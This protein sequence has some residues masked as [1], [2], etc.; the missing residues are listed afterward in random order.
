MQL[1]C[2][3]A[4]FGAREILTST[5]ISASTG[6]RANVSTST[7]TFTNTSARTSR[8][9]GSNTGTGIRTST[10]TQ[11]IGTGSYCCFRYCILLVVGCFGGCSSIASSQPFGAGK[12]LMTFYSS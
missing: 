11:C 8:G 5:G 6:K 10:M 9:T 3:V 12:F 4:A 2:D 1:N 7:G